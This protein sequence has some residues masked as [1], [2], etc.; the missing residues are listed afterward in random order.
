MSACR[1]GIAVVYMVD[2]HNDW[3]L[4]LHFRHIEEH[5]KTPYTV[6]ACINDLARP[7]RGSVENRPR[8]TIVPCEP[9]RPGSGLLRQ[10]QELAAR[11][12]LTAADAK[13]EHSWYLEQLI[14]AAIDDGVTHVAVLHADSFP[15]IPG[16]EKTLIRRL[17]DR[18]PLAGITRD[19]EF[20][21]KP[22]TAGILF[23][24][25]FYLKH[26]PRLLLTQD[27]LDSADYRRFKE[28]CPHVTDSGYGY[29]FR[30]F[31]D[32]LDWQ[33]LARTSPGG[34]R[35]A[36]ASI[37]GD[38][39]FHLHATAFVAKTGT[40]GFTAPLSSRSG[41]GAIGA[42]AARAFLP[43]AMQR[44]VRTLLQPHLRA[45]MESSDLE[46]WQCE[47]RQLSRDPER[48]ITELRAE[49]VS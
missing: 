11:K 4:D 32:G 8:V 16:W 12:G 13:H 21:R 14:R 30:M 36:I 19:V 35:R 48:F 7:L 26:H 25:E 40:L 42:R 22:L 41:P 44:W 10:D 15:V 27:E 37:Y 38:M 49:K 18:C 29:A 33:P 43:A 31:V 1:I 46:I 39:I 28:A 20:D 24:R 34:G 9:Y 2:E 17:S 47:R 5:T 6:Y 23:T 45:R 3:L